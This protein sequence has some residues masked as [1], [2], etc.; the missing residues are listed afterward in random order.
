MRHSRVA[1]DTGLWTDNEWG[2]DRAA[3]QAGGGEALLG[4]RRKA[5]G[6]RRTEQLNRPTRS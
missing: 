3:G 2:L 1:A 4:P 5:V 6:V